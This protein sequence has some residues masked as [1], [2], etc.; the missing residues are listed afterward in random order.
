MKE[1][2]KVSNNPFG[3]THG[4]PNYKR[5]VKEGLDS[6]RNRILEINADT[7][8]NAEFRDGLLKLID[9]M[10]SFSKRCIDYLV[11]VNADSDLIEALKNVP[12]K[13]AKTYYEGLVCWNTVF[14]FDGCD[15]LGCLD[16]GLAHLYNGEDLTDV[17]GELFSNLDANDMWSCAVRPNC[18]EITRQALKAIKGKRRP[19]IE[20]RVNNDTADDIWQ[21]AAENISGGCTNPSFYNEKGI[22]DMLH[23]RFPQISEDELSRFC[24]GGCTETNLEG[25][26]HAGGTDKNVNL[27]KAFEEYLYDSLCKKNALMISLKVLVRKPKR[28][29]RKQLTTQKRC[30]DTVQNIFRTQ[31]AHCYGMTVLTE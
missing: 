21:I 31:C 25:I 30:T 28:L 16:S 14:Y 12:F 22:H 5:I 4:S 19:L 2:S 11:S 13:P 20:L 7:T 1:F 27:L 17:I 24:G 9:S 8:E 10:K 26:T 29:Q 3:W 6:Y 18:N 23:T 15:N